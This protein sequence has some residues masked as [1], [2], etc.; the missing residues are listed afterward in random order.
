[1]F[2]PTGRVVFSLCL[3]LLVGSMLYMST[4]LGSPITGLAIACNT[5]GWTVLGPG[6]R[7][8]FWGGWKSCM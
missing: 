4:Q 1:M 8:T 3:V 7:S 6:P 5:R 2:K